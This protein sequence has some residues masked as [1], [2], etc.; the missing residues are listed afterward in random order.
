MT[1]GLLA[2]LVP[3]ADRPSPLRLR[4]GSLFRRCTRTAFTSVNVAGTTLYLMLANPPAAL[5]LHSHTAPTHAHAREDVPPGSRM[6]LGA[7]TATVL[8]SGES[9]QRDEKSAVK[10]A[11]M[12]AARPRVVFILGGPGSGKGT[13][14]SLL[15]EN[16]HGVTH[17]SAGDLL[18]AERDSGSEQ[19]EMINTYMKE[20]LIIPVSV[21]AGLL[22]KA[23]EGERGK[24]EVFLIDGFP[25]NDDNL[26]GWNS[27][28]GD[29]VQVEFMLLMECSEEVMLKRLLQRGAGSGRV[30]DNAE[31][32]RK[33]FNVYKTETLPVVS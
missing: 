9:D 24:S 13:Q 31:T 33:R 19:G 20:G 7:G 23:I 25:R 11:N 26:R 10:H 18:R 27:I 2:G 12:I 22:K 6:H 32:I 21:T 30:D 17:L 5:P 1:L 14:C 16:F 15:T 3:A 28:I 29:S 4:G 8:R